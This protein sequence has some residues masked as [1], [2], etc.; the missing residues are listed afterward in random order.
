[1]IFAFAVTVIYENRAVSHRSATLSLPAPNST[2]AKREGFQD[3]QQY[4]YCQRFRFVLIDPV[5]DGDG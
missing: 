2:L 3:V 1:V 5:A 4:G